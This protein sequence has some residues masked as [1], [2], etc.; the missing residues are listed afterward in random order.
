MRRI[1]ISHS[2]KSA[3]D[4]AYLDAIVTGLQAHPFDVW[5][6]RHS[7]SA[8]D[9]WNQKIGNNLVYCQGAVVLVSKQS[10]GSYYVQHEISNLLLRWRREKDPQRGDPGFPLCPVM[11]SADVIPDLELGFAKA[12]RFTDVNYIGA[13]PA[14]DVVA[15]LVDAFKDIPDF[16]DDNSP[17][18]A[19][20]DQI[21][22]I[23]AA[24]TLRRTLAGPRSEPGSR[25]RRPVVRSKRSRSNSRGAFSPIRSTRCTSFSWRSAPRSPTN[26]G[27][28][29]FILPR[30]RGSARRPRGVL[31]TRWPRIRRSPASSTLSC[32][33]SRRRCIFGVRSLELPEFAGQVIGVRGA[34]AGL[35]WLQ[36]RRNVLVAIAAK[37]TV[38]GDPSDAD[39]DT[40]VQSEIRSR[41]ASTKRPI[42]VATPV[43]E[44]DLDL[45]ARLRDDATFAGVTFMALCREATPADNTA[46]LAW[47][48][49]EL[50]PNQEQ[51]AFTTHN[52]LI[53]TLP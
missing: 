14:A 8:G 26:S 4:Q 34:T 11:L 20:E 13:R 39:F 24:P 29:C 40:K 27:G 45:I 42:L 9:D 16:N 18:A 2:A 7:L 21:T 5:L 51:A 6:D 38:D 31:P 15:Q 49:P 41:L 48:D 47:L 44:T 43:A 17:L 10:L 52:N 12:V 32:L 53:Q 46:G 23:L 25:R 30:P 36:L 3:A 22:A 19:V 37:L 28:T 35:A 50:Q 1:F 33:T